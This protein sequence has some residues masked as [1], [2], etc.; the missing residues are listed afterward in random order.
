MTRRT[1]PGFLSAGEAE[2]DSLRTRQM[3]RGITGTNEFQTQNNTDEASN[4]NFEHKKQSNQIIIDSEFWKSNMGL[5]VKAIVI[6]RAYN[7]D[8]ILKVTNLKE[9]DYLQAATELYQAELLKPYEKISGNF[10]VT[11]ELY[12]LCKKHFEG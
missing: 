2:L 1:R 5:I 12:Y 11:K 6:D 4:K 9:Q 8:A 3:V 10:S 7:K